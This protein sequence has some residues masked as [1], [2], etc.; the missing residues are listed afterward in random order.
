MATPRRRYHRLVS[1]EN[2]VQALVARGVVVPAPASV[3]V[4]DEVQPERIAPGVVIHTGCRIAGASTS[5]GPDSELGAEG[6]ATVEDCQLGRNVSLRGGYFSGA[7]FLDGASMGPSAHVRPGT[8]LE[9]ESCAAHSVGLKQTLFLSFATAGSLINFCDALLAGGTS[10]KNHSEIGSSYIHFNFTPHQD[11]ATPSLVGDVPRG[12]MLDQAPI[13]LGGQGGLVGPTR[14]AYGTVIPAGVIC[15][16]DVTEEGTMAVPPPPASGG[17]RAFTPGA[18]G[19]IGRVVKNNLIYVGNVQAL[20]LWYL[21]ARRRT[22]AAD[23]YSLACHAGAL[24]QIEAMLDERVVRLGELAQKMVRSLEL[25][26]SGAAPALPPA[27][28]AQQ[29]ALVRG[30]PQMEL[31]LRSGPAADAGADERDEFLAAWERLGTGMSHV[32]AVASLPP[33]AKRAGTAWLQAVV[34]SA[35][36]VWTV[37]GK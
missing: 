25:A 26:R 12:V 7:V 5:I 33:E 37:A 14:I 24:A 4:G 13:F 1:A 34:D 11:K 21:H 35:A 31:E 16:K 27:A 6:P 36:A 28:E 22:M 29:E 19:P 23:R 8:L 2:M 3:E 30:W 17:S 15:R 32:D 9:E 10:R 20:K 18:Y